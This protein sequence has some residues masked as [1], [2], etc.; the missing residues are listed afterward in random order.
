MG[1][2]RHLRDSKTERDLE[3]IVFEHDTEVSRYSKVHKITFQPIVS[4]CD[5]AEAAIPGV[6]G[7]DPMERYAIRPLSCGCR[8]QSGAAPFNCKIRG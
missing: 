7:V 4:A 2:V 3:R 6:L 1:S 5:R 8:L